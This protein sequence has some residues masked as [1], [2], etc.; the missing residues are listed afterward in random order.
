MLLVGHMCHMDTRF[1][2]TTTYF[3]ARK[4]N[5]KEKGTRCIKYENQPDIEH[6]FPV[7]KKQA[8]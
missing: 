6:K 3:N 8:R 4:E 7:D 5:S 2:K 1:H